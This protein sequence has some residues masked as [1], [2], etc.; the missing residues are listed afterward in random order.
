MKRAPVLLFLSSLFCSGYAIAA[1]ITGG[2]TSV[3]LNSGFVSTITGAG[4]T[5]AA[6]PPGMLT[7]TTATFPITGGDTSTG[8]ID[9][10]GG[11]SFTKGSDS[12]VVE[13]F[14]I[15]LN[16]DL[17]SGTVIANSGMPAMGVDLFNIGAGDT[18]TINSALASDLSVV[19]DVP[20]L[21]GATVGVATVSPIVTSTPEPA[22]AGLMAVAVLFLAGIRAFA[23]RP[24]GSR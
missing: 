17:L 13:N 19:F 3:V 14:V 1:T 23:R 6:V 20:N 24:Y 5:P 4:I 21:T 12:A 7:A 22:D 16:T 8:I 15:N 10:S 2:T 9:H 18:L 11:F